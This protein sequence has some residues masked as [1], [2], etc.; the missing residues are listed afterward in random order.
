MGSCHVHF[1]NMQIL[2]RQHTHPHIQEYPSQ[3]GPP[4]PKSAGHGSLRQ[5]LGRKRLGDARRACENQLER[6][7]FYCHLQRLDLEWMRCKRKQHGA[8]LPEQLVCY[9]GCKLPDSQ[10]EHGLQPELGEEQL[11]SLQLLRRQS[12]L[13]NQAGRMQLQHFVARYSDSCQKPTC[14]VWSYQPVVDQKSVYIFIRCFGCTPNHK[15]WRISTTHISQIYWH[16]D[17]VGL[18]TA[19][20][21]LDSDLTHPLFGA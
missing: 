17:L 7:S 21:I 5:C 2:H 1:E 13:S 15:I 19:M 20:S 9:P 6:R 18:K 12:S 4:I 8:D 11:G 16:I 10:P 14:E 3:H